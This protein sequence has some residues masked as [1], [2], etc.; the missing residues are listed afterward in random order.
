MDALIIGDA[1]VNIITVA[2]LIYF[3]REPSKAR[4]QVPPKPRETPVQERL[5]IR[6]QN[7]R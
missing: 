6:A 5:R 7:G 3:L 2:I 1:L 4:L